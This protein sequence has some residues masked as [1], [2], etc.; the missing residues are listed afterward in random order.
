MNSNFLHIP[1]KCKI[2]Q[3]DTRCNGI[4]ILKRNCACVSTFVKIVWKPLSLEMST[5]IGVRSS[6]ML[7]TEIIREQRDAEAE[8]LLK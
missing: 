7:S 2:E 6:G 8:N 1:Y 3:T 4:K 5:A